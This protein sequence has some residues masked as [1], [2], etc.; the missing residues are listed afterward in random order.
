MADTAAARSEP[1]M[2]AFIL[3]TAAGKSVIDE[4]VSLMRGPRET[5]GI[6]WS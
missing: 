2:K 4:S 3:T 5:R 6:P 1:T